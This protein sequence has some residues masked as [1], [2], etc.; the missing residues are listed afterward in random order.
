[1]W[2]EL[3]AHLFGSG[4][5]DQKL[6]LFQNNMKFNINHENS[7][8][9][10][11]CHTYTHQYYSDIMQTSMMHTLMMTRYLIGAITEDAP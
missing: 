4:D 11:G 5:E 9:I 2:G 6:I 1:M 8:I 10:A 7:A 3:N